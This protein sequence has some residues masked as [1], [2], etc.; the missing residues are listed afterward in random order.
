M[1]NIAFK[2]LGVAEPEF[3]DALNGVTPC[4]DCI[5]YTYQ[6]EQSGIN[7]DERIWTTR[8]LDTEG[9]TTGCESSQCKSAW[10]MLGEYVVRFA[11]QL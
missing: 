8:L 7:W 10:T 3:E 1:D 11:G 5:K 9:G 4:V 2:E 6:V